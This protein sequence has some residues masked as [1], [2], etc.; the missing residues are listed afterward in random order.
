MR[1]PSAMSSQRPALYLVPARPLPI[2]DDEVSDWG[3]DDQFTE[4]ARIMVAYRA[5]TPWERLKR[6]LRA[7]FLWG[8]LR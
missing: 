1:E 8:W 5:P 6:W 4:L 7:R 3:P 2:L